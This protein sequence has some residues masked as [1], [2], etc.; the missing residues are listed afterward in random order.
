MGMGCTERHQP[1]C[2]MTEGL[3]NDGA[4]AIPRICQTKSTPI[5]MDQTA[6]A[7]R[8]LQLSA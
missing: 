2:R 5:G 4:R 3:P 6:T 7:Q 8:R 1:I